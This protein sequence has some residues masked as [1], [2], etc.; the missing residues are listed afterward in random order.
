[1][2]VLNMLSTVR[3]KWAPSERCALIQGILRNLRRLDTEGLELVCIFVAR[4]TQ[5]RNAA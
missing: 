5:G 4:F 1:M 2:I 3:R